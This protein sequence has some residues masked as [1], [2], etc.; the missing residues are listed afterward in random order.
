MTPFLTQAIE[1]DNALGKAKAKETLE[2]LMEEYPG[3]SWKVD[4]KGGV[5]F[6]RLIDLRLRGNWGMNIKLKTIDHDAAVFKR[7]VKYVAGE[8]L[9]R[10]GLVRG[11]KD[12]TKITKVDG[13]P[14]RHIWQPTT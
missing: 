2:I 3:Y 6:I 14:E 9:E 10:A 5:C 4:V 11:I 13:V 7:K 8:F 12:G 1:F